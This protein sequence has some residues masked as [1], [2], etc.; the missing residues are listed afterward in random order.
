MEGRELIVKSRTGTG[1]TLSFLL[2]LT[3]LI[4]PKARKPTAVIMEPT[5]ELANQVAKQVENFTELRSVAVYGGGESKQMQLRKIREVRPQII[6]AT[7]GRLIDMLNNNEID[8]S[9]VGYYILDEGDKMLDMGFHEDI[10]RI[11]SELPEHK[12]MVFSATVPDFIQG[13]AT[14]Y[15]KDPLMIDLVGDKEN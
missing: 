12:A 4:D 1:K 11:Q 13:L 14:K 7:P 10:E 8:L 15:M 6:I 3:T 5:R 2:P 9:G